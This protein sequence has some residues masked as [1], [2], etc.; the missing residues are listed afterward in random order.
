MSTN[1][2]KSIDKMDLLIKTLESKGK[3]LENDSKA[4]VK[5]SLQPQFANSK[6]L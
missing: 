6:L 3:C 1:S 2:S 4:F 5:N